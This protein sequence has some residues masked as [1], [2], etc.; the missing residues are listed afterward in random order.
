VRSRSTMR[1]SLRVSLSLRCSEA[2]VSALGTAAF[3]ALSSAS[4]I[5][6]V[7]AKQRCAWPPPIGSAH[8][9]LVRARAGISVG[10][11]RRPR[12]EGAA[13]TRSDP[14]SGWDAIPG[15][16]FAASLSHRVHSETSAQCTC[17]STQGTANGL[18]RCGARSGQARHMNTVTEAL[19]DALEVEERV[20]GDQRMWDGDQ[21]T[22]ERW[23]V[24]L[25]ARRGDRWMTPSL[26]LALPDDATGSQVRG[27]TTRGPV[28]AV[29]PPRQAV[30]PGSAVPKPTASGDLRR[31]RT[32]ARCPGRCRGAQAICAPG[33]GL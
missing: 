23:G 7:R 25:D 12:L 17:H 14:E 16:P 5:A 10:G 4:G 19:T 33:F 18:P 1:W 15:L 28:A 26:D 21:A 9:F 32:P 8:P 24:P 22:N 31:D 30:I 6:Q 3:L 13:G 11:R 29:Q 2:V 27:G 20:L